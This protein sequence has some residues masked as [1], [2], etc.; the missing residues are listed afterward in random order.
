VTVLLLEL[1]LDGHPTK[2]EM[3]TGDGLLSL[4]P[5]AAPAALHGNVVRAA[6]VEHVTLPWSADHILIAVGSPVTAAAAASLLAGRI[7]V[8]EGHSVPA[9]MIETGLTVGRATWRV[10]RFSE[11]RWRLLAADGSAD[12]A[13]EID[14]V[15]VPEFKN[16]AAWPL[17]ADPAG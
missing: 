14:D 1:D 6:G 15:G 11:R 7:G 5:E 12:I 16:G 8:G 9:V 2:L 4:H 10:L 13:I 3:A 17:E